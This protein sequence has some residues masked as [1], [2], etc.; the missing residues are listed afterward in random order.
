MGQGSKRRFTALHRITKSYKIDE[1]DVL[2]MDV[3]PEAKRPKRKLTKEDKKR[4]WES[5]R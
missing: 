2:N 4:K 5:D 1:L 3:M